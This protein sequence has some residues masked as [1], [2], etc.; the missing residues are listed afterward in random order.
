MIASTPTL[1]KKQDGIICSFPPCPDCSHQTTA[2]ANNHLLLLAN[3]SGICV[4]ACI[5]VN[6]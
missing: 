2:I 6:V 1:S 5:T 3:G 4:L